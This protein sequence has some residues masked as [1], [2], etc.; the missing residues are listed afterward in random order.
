MFPNDQSWVHSYVGSKIPRKCR[1]PIY[2]SFIIPVIEFGFHLYDNSPKEHLENLQ[3]AQR[4]SL[5]FVTGANKR[6]HTR[7]CWI[8]TPGKENTVPESSNYI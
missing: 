1:L 5:F 8:A 3:K 6:P 2:V 4:P 7:I